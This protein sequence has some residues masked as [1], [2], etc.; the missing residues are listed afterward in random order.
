MD[1]ASRCDRLLLMR[2]GELLADDTPDQLL[3]AIGVADVEAAFL[4]LVEQKGDAAASAPTVSRSIH[5][6]VAR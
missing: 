3:A 1:E 5:R 2:G 4:A 6:K